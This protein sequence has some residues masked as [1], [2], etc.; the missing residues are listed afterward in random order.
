VFG[1]KMDKIEYGFNRRYD[2]FNRVFEGNTISKVA[3]ACPRASVNDNPISNISKLCTPKGYSIA[4]G[5]L[6]P[7]GMPVA[8]AYNAIVKTALE[9]G[10]NYLVCFESDMI[11]PQN[12]LSKMLD[13]MDK[14][15]I[16]FICGSYVLKDTTGQSTALILDE[17]NCVKAFP[18]PFVERGLVECNW[19]VPMGCCI[20]NLDM[21]ADIPFPWFREVY[22][23]PEQPAEVVFQGQKKIITQTMTQD[24]YFCENLF[25][26]GLKAY[27]DT[28]IQCLH[29]D[30]NS[31][32]VFG[33]SK[34]VTENYELKA[35]EIFRFALTEQELPKMKIIQNSFPSAK[36]GA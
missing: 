29:L 8:E 30:K 11:I 32:R 6:S 16:P 34:Y 20:I 3:I 35:D 22:A 26:A 23:S 10:V 31:G 9:N 18:E 17:N 21:C 13:R 14:E 28:D 4:T 7:V 19:V 2:V 25:R 15:K 5:L 27:I 24:A 33:S 1:K 36:F 12:S